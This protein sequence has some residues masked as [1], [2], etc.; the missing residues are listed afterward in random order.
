M[1]ASLF[2]DGWSVTYTKFA[3]SLGKFRAQAGHDNEEVGTE[4]F[5]VYDLSLP[6]GGEGYEI[7]TFD[8]P[9]GV[10]DHFGYAISADSGPSI[11]IAGTATKGG[12][13]KMFDWSFTMKLGYAHCQGEEESVVDGK[14][15]TVQATIHGDHVFYDD[16]TS[17]EPN[18][19]F[20]IFADSDTDN[21]NMITLAE[22]AAKDIR[23]Q[24]RYQVGSTK[25]LAGAEI[26]NLRQF[27]EVQIGTIGHFNG[28]GHCEDVI[29][30]P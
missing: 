18:V 12:V 1:P 26:T 16:L 30:I 19:S 5:K 17:P 15:L 23:T 3:V 27:L 8:A 25:D 2:N 22:L 9:G 28:E 29:A 10:Y 24:T 20:Q 14:N 13:T 11:A 4:T 7:A 21:N 6:S